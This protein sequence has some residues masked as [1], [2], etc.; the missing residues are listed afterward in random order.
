MVP[1]LL[2]SVFCPS[3]MPVSDGESSWTTTV[4]QVPSGSRQAAAIH[5]KAVRRSLGEVFILQGNG[6]EECSPKLIHKFHQGQKKMHFLCLNRCGEQ[7][8]GPV[9]PPFPLISEFLTFLFLDC[10]LVTGNRA[11][12]SSAF[13]HLGLLNEPGT[14]VHPQWDLS[15]WVLKTLTSA[16]FKP[17]QLQSF[18]LKSLPLTLLASGSAKGQSPCNLSLGCAA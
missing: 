17:L 13:R 7:E 3:P 8:T 9:L 10:Q 4:R 14:R 5:W 6:R 18:G 11:I 2:G 16:S 1:G 15:Q 12:I